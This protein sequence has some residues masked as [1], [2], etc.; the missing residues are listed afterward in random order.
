MHKFESFLAPVMESFIAFRQVS[1][2]W[3]DTD[4]LNIRLFDR[5][6]ATMFSG[7]AEL[8]Q[9]MVDSWCRRRDTELLSNSHRG[10]IYVIFHFVNYLKKRNLTEINAPSI[11]VKMPRTYIPHAFTEEELENFFNACD[12][13]PVTPRRRDVLLR[14][15]TVP[16][17]FRL[18]YSSGIRTNEARL[19]RVSDTNLENG[20]LNI[21]QSKG[22]SQHFIVLHDTMTDLMRRYDSAMRLFY[23]ERKYF[24]PSAR[25]SHY[26]QQWVVVNFRQL[27]HKYNTAHAVAY[28]LRHNYAIE[29]INLWIGEGFGFFDK[30]LYL[31]RSMGHSDLE[32]TKYYYSLVPALNGI[33][34]RLTGNNF[35]NTIPNLNWEK[36]S[37]Y[38]VEMEE[39]EHEE[40]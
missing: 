30:L 6:C 38:D 3:N 12:N 29:N 22:H 17:F 26:T 21:R 14:R 33:L 34:S 35:N 13:L 16:V 37:I 5:H 28:Q 11:P 24:F 25:D 40:V 36:K 2:R 23:P 1:G 8:T 32:S 20:V 7:A 31:S 9:E 4:S 10:R 19:L 15:I 18:L 39:C 27:W